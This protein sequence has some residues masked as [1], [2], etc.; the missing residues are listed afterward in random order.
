MAL[1]REFALFVV[2]GVVAAIG[3]Y[4]TLIALASGLRAD[5]VLS[6]ALG[7]LVGGLISYVLNYHVTFRA[8]RDHAAALPMF[9]TVAGV[10]FVLNGAA[11]ALLTKA[12]GLHYLPAQILTTGLLLVWHFLAN[13]LWTFRPATGR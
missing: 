5:P 10:G 9:F 12:V 6:S 11:M 7:F 13:R 8:T 3:H 2:V 4:G 1:V